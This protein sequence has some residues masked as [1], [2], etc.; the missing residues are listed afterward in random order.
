MATVLPFRGLRYNTHQTLDLAMVT[1]PPYDVISPEQQDDLYDAHPYNVVRLILNK[2]TPQDNER[3]NRYTRAAAFL[4]EWIAAGVLMRERK[5][6]LYL[7]EQEFTALGRTMIRRGF[8]ARVALEEFGQGTIYPH[9]QTFAKHKEDRLKLLKATHCNL[10]QVMALYPDAGGE[11]MGVFERFPLSQPDLLAVDDG[12]IVN[13]MWIVTDEEA[14]ADVA[15]AMK[16]RPLYIADGHHRYTT[17]LNYRAYLREQGENVTDHH[18]ANYTTITCISMS[19]PGLVI[20][21]THRVLS[22]QPAL[23]AEQLRDLLKPHFAWKA[24]SGAEATSSRMEEHL[25]ATGKV[26]FG[27]YVRGDQ[28]A[29]VATL[30]DEAIMGKLAADHSADWQKLDVAVLHRLVFDHLLAPK[31]GGPDK[32]SIR[33]TPR[34]GDAFDAVHEAGATLAFLMRPTRMDQVETI[35]GHGELLPQKSTFFYPKLL[36][37]LVMNMLD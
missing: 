11:V 29:Y 35:A 18:P 16:R 33:Y 12:G 24:Y 19:D 23:T 3:N 5:P 28:S 32:L 31:F 37:G 8:V 14:I 22:N 27:L 15:E 13:R 7:Y 17:A 4:K 30:K 34:A 21:P 25:S 1:A 6:A 20:Q 9:E 2:D 36:T 26:C 10:S